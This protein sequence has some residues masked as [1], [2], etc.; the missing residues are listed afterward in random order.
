MIL[1]I[2][3]LRQ[4]LEIYASII[5]PNNLI[6]P[7]L[8][9]VMIDTDGKNVRLTGSN[10]HE[11][12]I[13]EFEC[14]FT[15]EKES[16]LI[17]YGTF[18]KYLKLLNEPS[19][20]LT[21]EEKKAGTFTQVSI[22]IN[23]GESNSRIAG[24]DPK[25]YPQVTDFE[26]K[27]QI[28]LSG[29]LLHGAAS[30][31]LP[32]ASNDELLPHINGVNA[33]CQDGKVI[34][35]ST[36]KSNAAQ[37]KNEIA[38]KE[39][40]EV[41][42]HNNISTIANIFELDELTIERNDDKLR[43]SQDN[44]TFIGNLITDKFPDM[45]AMISGLPKPIKLTIH[46]ESFINELRRCELFVR[47]NNEVKFDLKNSTLTLKVDNPD[48]DKEYQNSIKIDP[49]EAEFTIHLNGNKLLKA[50]SLM[51]SE[52]ISLLYHGEKRAV[53]LQDENY[54]VLSSPFSPS[55]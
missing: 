9:N 19:I 47:K 26:P 25:D 31:V 48:F 7:I 1:P 14:E 23:T 10:L 38:S 50:A 39:A 22:V 49:V 24:D 41:H 16:I 42:F 17:E 4:E 20:K 36:D 13:K 3:Q 53:I 46:R 11:T 40:F 33:R 52:E 44:T 35:E 55:F 30:K 6:V 28:V 2:K 29:E 18:I 12:I 51:S 54:T 37:W 27:E 34:M 8:E 32:F 15:N 5:R 21:K 45:E 43:I